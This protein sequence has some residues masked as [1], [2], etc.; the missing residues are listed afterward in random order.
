MRC[1]YRRVTCPGHGAN[2]I[3]NSSGATRGLSP[4][5]FLTYRFAHRC[6]FLVA[7]RR[8]GPVSAASTRWS[9]SS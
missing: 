9:L 4:S 6:R 7:G 3:N 8:M 2:V 5:P 1:G